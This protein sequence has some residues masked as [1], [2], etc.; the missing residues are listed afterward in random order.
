MH[1]QGVPLAIGIDA[2][3]L[4]DEEDGLRELRLTYLLHAGIS[5]DEGLTK[6]A[7][8]D[9]A[10][11]NGARAVTGRP[12][13]G[14]L[15]RSMAADVVLLDFGKLASDVM[16]GVTPEVEVVLS[17]AS[18]R[19]VKALV[20]DGV[21]IVRD[22]QVLGVDVPAI[23]AELV[24]QAKAVAQDYVAAQPMLETLQQTLRQCYRDGLHRAVR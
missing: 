22:G 1:R 4:D 13:H 12:N 10:L 18:A 9:A 2:L 17:R 21:E 14:R 15:E 5:F 7:L 16:P 6:A 20:I 23:E 24:A 3:G 8:L 19:H 11:A